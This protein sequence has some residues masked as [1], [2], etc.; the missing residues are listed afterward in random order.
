MAILHIFSKMDLTTI[1]AS[2]VGFGLEDKKMIDIEQ[3]QKA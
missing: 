1:E 2:M 3:I